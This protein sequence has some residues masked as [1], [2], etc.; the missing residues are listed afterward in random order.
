MLA[1]QDFDDAEELPIG[2]KLLNGQFLIQARLQS[3]GFGIT[4]IARDS[5][6]R[7][8]VV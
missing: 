3:G 8:V 1:G 4:Y 7:Q 5:L 6:A 2:A